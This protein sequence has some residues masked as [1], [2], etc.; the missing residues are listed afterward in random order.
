MS[1]ISSLHSPLQ[2]QKELF[3]TLHWTRLFPKNVSLILDFRAQIILRRIAMEQG[4]SSKHQ[5]V[6][7]KMRNP[8]LQSWIFLKNLKC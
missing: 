1:G 2:F 4:I 8:L 6:P 7:T 3:Q 5:F